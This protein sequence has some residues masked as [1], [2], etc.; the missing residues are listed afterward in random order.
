MS[1]Y[2]SV[3]VI[4]YLPAAGWFKSSLGQQGI[5]RDDLSTRLTKTGPVGPGDMPKKS[6]IA[7]NFKEADENSNKVAS[8]RIF[9]YVLII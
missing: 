8:I 2:H 5:V 4:G 9:F 6:Q 1:A 3:L 7:T